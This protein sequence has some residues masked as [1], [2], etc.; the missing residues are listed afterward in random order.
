MRRLLP[1]DLFGAGDLRHNLYSDTL[2]SLLVWLCVLV[3]LSV[4][5]WLS[6]SGLS[7]FTAQIFSKNYS[8]AI[9]YSR[10]WYLIIS[11]SLCAFAQLFCWLCQSLSSTARLHSIMIC[12]CFFTKRVTACLNNVSTLLPFYLTLYFFKLCQSARNSLSSR[13]HLRATLTLFISI[14]SADSVTSSWDCFI[15]YRQRVYWSTGSRLRYF[16]LKV[17]CLCTRKML[18]TG[19]YG[20]KIS[21]DDD[22]TGRGKSH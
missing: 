7:S 14:S 8:R 22:S 1:W 3:Q 2:D 12:L 15:C 10:Y 9:R 16:F 20:S 4:L 19:A 21:I 11:A 5:V 18:N 13:L 6:G 17:R